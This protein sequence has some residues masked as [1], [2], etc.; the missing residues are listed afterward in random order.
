MQLHA[1]V[2]SRPS[3]MQ[4]QESGGHAKLARMQQCM[5]C[6]L[7]ATLQ[8]IGT[9]MRVPCPWLAA[10]DSLLQQLTRRCWLQQLLQC[11][12]MGMAMMRTAA[13]LVSRCSFEQVAICLWAWAQLNQPILQPPRG[14][15]EDAAAGMMP[16]AD[17]SGLCGW[18]R[19]LANRLGQA[20]KL[21]QAAPLCRQHVCRAAASAA[22]WF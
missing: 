6:T 9:C 12:A 20:S 15:L 17:A 22:S 2:C 1:V 8:C 11:A 7:S 19:L 10:M 4:L 14:T 3:G 21:R 18:A 16:R 13:A 5:T